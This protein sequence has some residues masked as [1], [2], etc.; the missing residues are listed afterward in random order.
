[1]VR[2]LS[3]GDVSLDEIDEG[4]KKSSSLEQLINNLQNLQRKQG[5]HNQLFTGGG[6]SPESNHEECIRTLRELDETDFSD[7]RYQAL[8]ARFS[9]LPDGVR[10]MAKY[11]VA[12][13]YE[14][15]SAN[16]PFN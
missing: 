2:E 16:H 9:D 8:E 4:I 1:M 7:I 3:Y 13:H 12:Q 6:A 15:I 5:G 10:Q 14:N 11:L